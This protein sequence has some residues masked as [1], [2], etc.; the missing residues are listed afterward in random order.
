[1]SAFN[2]V[3]RIAEVDKNDSLTAFY[4]LTGQ[5]EFLKNHFEGFPVMPG[6]LLIESLKQ[7]ALSLLVLSGDFEKDFFRLVSVEEAK[8]GQFV[9]PVSHL[10]I[11]V[12]ILKKEGM[13]NFFEGRIDRVAMPS[14]TV[15]GKALSATLTLAPERWT[16]EQKRE[17]FERFTGLQSER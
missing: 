7:A 3:D 1:M 13:T 2:L 6:A 10:K 8:F 5:E 11:S 9:Q 17:Y 14:E 16:T 4:T 12:R 15:L